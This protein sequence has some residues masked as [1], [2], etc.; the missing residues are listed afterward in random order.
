MTPFWTDDIEMLLADLFA[1]LVDD[2]TAMLVYVK[3]LTQNYTVHSKV[4]YAC[5][6]LKSMSGLIRRK[7]FS[8]ALEVGTISY[9]IL[10][11]ITLTA[12]VAQRAKDFL[13]LYL[14]QFKT[15]MTIIEELEKNENRE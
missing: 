9:K 12:K 6:D 5:E 15:L 13:K 8:N 2:S 3:Q 11:R 10:D 1:Q 14:Q 7:K 4:Y